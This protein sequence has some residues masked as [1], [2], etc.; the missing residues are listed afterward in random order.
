VLKPHVDQ[1]FAFEDA[2]AMYAASQRGHGRGKKV[3]V[4]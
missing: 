4:L 3:L 2:P 1:V